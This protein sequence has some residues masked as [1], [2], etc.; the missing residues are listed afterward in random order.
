MDILLHAGNYLFSYRVAGICVQNRKILLQKP[1]NDTAY[2]IPGGH[3]KFGE[4]NAETLIREFY[5]EIG[6][7]I[8]VGDLKWVGELFF[9]GTIS[10]TIRFAFIIS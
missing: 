6:A 2:V 8:S 5:E 9:R 7:A 4:T 1:V 10:H 3:A